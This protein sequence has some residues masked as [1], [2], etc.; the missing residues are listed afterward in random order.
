MT[1]DL[2]PG[3]VRRDVAVD[4]MRFSLW[5][6]DPG[7]QG[8]DPASLALATRSTP[9][10]ML[11]HGVPETAAMWRDLLAELGSDRIVLAP[12][13]PGLG[14]SELRGPYDARTVAARIA[15]LA[16]H[17]LDAPVDIVGHDWGGVVGLTLAASRP[18]LVRRLVV[19]NAAYRYVD[20]RAAWHLPTASL[21][22]LPELAFRVG[23][24]SLVG[25]VIR[26]GWHADRPVA[27]D[28]LAH[29]QDAYADPQRI[30]AMLGYYRD[31][32]R[33]RAAA[34]LRGVAGRARSAPATVDARRRSPGPR[35]PSL[36]VWGA[37]DPVLPE[38]VRASVVRDLGDCRCVVIPHA[39]HFVLEEAP[40]TAIPAI[41]AFL[42]EPDALVEPDG[43]VA[44]S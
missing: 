40:E 44:G 39:G 36:V 35:M 20:L 11:L 18:D 22:G 13:L 2:V 25:Q 5:R 38:S 26:V 8:V 33:P 27:P 23:G 12:D 34:A 14:S 30:A 28:L 17:E 6:S 42:R 3:G 1:R 32:F 16:L 4:G 21:P 29:Y 31:N 43:E 41:A 37:L 10:A 9:A 19:L 15:A 24:R 7:P